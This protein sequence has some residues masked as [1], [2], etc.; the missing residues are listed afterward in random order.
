MPSWMTLT[1]PLPRHQNIE[2]VGYLHYPKA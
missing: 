1:P 2:I